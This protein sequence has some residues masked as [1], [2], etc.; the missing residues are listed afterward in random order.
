[1]NIKVELEKDHTRSQALKIAN[2][3]CLSSKNFKDLMVCFWDA[4]NRIAQKA[5]WC[6]SWSAKSKKG[7]SETYISDFINQVIIPNNK[8]AIVRNSLRI[9]ELLNIPED[10]HGELMNAC[11]SFVENPLTAIAIKAFS[12]TILFNLSKTYPE[13]QDE[14]ICIIEENWDHETPAFKSRGQ[15]IIS[16]INKSRKIR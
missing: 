15:K 8:V 16:N 12:L 14:L 9:L 1:M 11:F 2:Y 4:D 7:F 5:A 3:A 13:I 10:F 6:V